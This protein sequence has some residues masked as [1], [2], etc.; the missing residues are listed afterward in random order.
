VTA[1][2]LIIVSI[3]LVVPLS[4]LRW[5]LAGGLLSLVTDA[6]DII[7]IQLLD[8]GGVGDYQRLDKYLDMYYLSLEAVVV[9]GWLLLPRLTATMLFAYRVIGVA[10]F[11]VTDVRLFLFA[12]PN[13]FENFFLFYLVVLQ[14]FPDYVLTIRRLVSWLG[15]LLIP[16]MA[17]EYVI[18]YAR[19]L[20]ELVAVD[21]I[22]DVSWAVIDWLRDIFGLLWRSWPSR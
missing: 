1:E 15:I 9:Q 7:L 17:Q 3:R 19:L 13:L 21:I 11:E 5:P 18:H 2:T 16:K 12:F 22:A 4:I 14:F 8:L 10:L 20:D 6:L